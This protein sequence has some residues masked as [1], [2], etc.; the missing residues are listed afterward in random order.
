MALHVDGPSTAIQDGESV[1]DEVIG[2][3][4]ERKGKSLL[5]EWER[6]N[7]GEVDKRA[8]VS[9]LKSI[10][11]EYRSK[12]E[13]GK[14]F[15]SWDLDGGGSLDV[16]EIRLALA[17]GSQ[18]A[19]R[20]SPTEHLSPTEASNHPL[21]AVTM[22]LLQAAS[23]GN[24]SEISRIGN[25]SHPACP[26]PHDIR[27]IIQHRAPEGQT[28]LHKAMMSGQSRNVLQVLVQMGFDVDALDNQGRSPLMM[29]A[30]NKQTASVQALLSMG[31]TGLQSALQ[32]AALGGELKTVK[33]LLDEIGDA[34]SPDWDKS[35]STAIALPGWFTDKDS[36]GRDV[37][38]NARDAA[39]EQVVL[40]LQER[41]KV[42]SERASAFAQKSKEQDKQ[43]QSALSRGR[44][45][46]V[47]SRA[48]KPP[49]PTISG[50][51]AK[52]INALFQLEKSAASSAAQRCGIP[53]LWDAQ[54]ERDTMVRVAF[55]IFDADGDG[56]VTRKDL[57]SAF[58]VPSG[59][60]PMLEAQID[61]I[62]EDCANRGDAEED[63]LGL[64]FRGFAASFR[65]W[66]GLVEG[67]P[68]P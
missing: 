23:S 54:V 41:L 30:I 66:R 3:L 9:G 60:V 24:I 65:S 21:H 1:M 19:Q 62:F 49:A 58:V 35:S 64:P 48:V 16:K 7:C 10:G 17:A 11:L 32:F 13:L 36:G 34:P 27:A 56:A 52:R 57:H 22:S 45:K 5:H 68:S 12:A 50:A 6:E 8:F 37:L 33:I 39:D 42:A 63:Q 14:V 44:W 15:S 47:K 46:A 18:G 55:A 28:A 25:G 26:K 43:Q 4:K 61:S 38:T 2:L 59:G 51:T 20:Q 40:Y 29:G 53:A 31:A 67:N